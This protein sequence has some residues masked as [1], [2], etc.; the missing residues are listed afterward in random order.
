M[1]EVTVGGHAHCAI[2]Q[3]D[4]EVGEELVILH[5]GKTEWDPSKQEQVI[6]DVRT[7]IA[8]KMCFEEVDPELI[9]T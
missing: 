4:I 3:R 9:L 5:L 1:I 8:H 6:L 7:R 2:C